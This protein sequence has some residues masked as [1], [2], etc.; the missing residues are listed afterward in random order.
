MTEV[1]QRD[2][3]APVR[4]AMLARDA[5][6]LVATFAPD[7]VLL[8][9]VT[10]R[11]FRGREEV[12]ELMTELLAALEDLEYTAVAVD[13]DTYL[14]AFRVRLGGREV[15]LVDLMRFDDEGRL[16]EIVVHA[17]PMAGAALFA[18]VVGPRIARRRA[19]WRGVAAQA[20]RPLPRAL[21]ALDAAGMRLMRG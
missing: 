3:F 11:P 4:A 10:A 17:R 19:R 5:D 20:A 12:G 6:A 13:G 14:V 1:Q 2:D 18:G 7:V 15:Q 9:P 16:R 8:S 21:R